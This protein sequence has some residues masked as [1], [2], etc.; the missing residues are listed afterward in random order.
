MDHTIG[1]E[2]W[3]RLLTDLESPP[4]NEPAAVTGE[5]MNNFSAIFKHLQP[6]AAAR[7]TKELEN[8]TIRSI[9]LF[10]EILEHLD[11]HNRPLL[12]SYLSMLL[13]FGYFRIAQV[14]YYI[15]LPQQ[16]GQSSESNSIYY[17]TIDKKLKW[18][19][20]SPLLPK[21]GSIGWKGLMNFG[22]VKEERDLMNICLKLLVQKLHFF[23]ILNNLSQYQDNL[24][25]IRLTGKEV[26]NKLFEL[27]RT[28]AYDED[29]VV[30]LDRSLYNL[31]IPFTDT[32]QQEF[33]NEAIVQDLF[34][35][36][37]FQKPAFEKQAN[38]TYSL[39]THCIL[40]KSS[41][42]ESFF[43]KFINH[44]QCNIIRRKRRHSME[45]SE[46]G[47]A[48]P[49]ALES[50]IADLNRNPET[51]SIDLNKSQE[52]DLDDTKEIETTFVSKT[53]VSLSGLMS[54]VMK[55]ELKAKTFQYSY[56]SNWSSILRRI[57]ED[58]P[59]LTF[60][61]TRKIFTTCTILL[62][63]ISRIENANADKD[64]EDIVMNLSWISAKSMI[65]LGQSRYERF[66]A[67]CDPSYMSVFSKSLAEM[68]M[69]SLFETPLM[70]IYIIYFRKYFA[71][72]D[73]RGCR[74]DPTKM[75]EFVSTICDKKVTRHAS[76]LLQYTCIH[77]LSTLFDGKINPHGK[78]INN[79]AIWT[80][81]CCNKLIK[82]IKKRLI[83]KYDSDDIPTE[84]GDET[85]NI[86]INLDSESENTMALDS[87]ICILKI[88][89]MKRDQT[90]LDT[91]G[92]LVRRLFGSIQNRLLRLDDLLKSGSR[93]DDFAA[94]D[95]H[96][97]KLLQL[98]I[99]NKDLIKVYLDD[100]IVE[101]IAVSWSASLTPIEKSNGSSDVAIKKST[102]AHL[103]T[104]LDALEDKARDNP[105][106]YQTIINQQYNSAVD[107][108]IGSTSDTRKEKQCCHRIL[109]QVRTLSAATAII[110]GG[111]SIT[112]SKVLA[113]NIIKTLE[114][115]DPLDH[116]MVL[117]SILMLKSLLLRYKRD[118]KDQ[119][120]PAIIKLLPNI[121]CGLFRI[122][123]SVELGPSIHAFTNAGDHKS[124]RSIQCCTYSNCVQIYTDLFHLMS[125]KVT[126]T[127]VTDAF[128]LAISSN[129][130][131]YAKHS[132]RLHRYFTSLA[133]SIAELL[134]AICI[135]RK[136]DD[137]L[138]K[139]MPI[140]LSVL[141][142]LMRCIMLAS[143]RQILDGLSSKGDNGQITNEFVCDT[144][145]LAIYEEQL[146]I[147]AL[148][149]GRILNNLS[150]LRVKLVEFAPHL[151]STFVKD[152]QRASCPD[153]IK[154]HLN[155][156][157]FRICNLIDAHQRERREALVEGAGQRKTVSGHASGSLFEMIHAR[158][159]QAS[160]EIFR[161]MHENYSHFHRYLGKC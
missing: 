41:T 77:E 56:L 119:S 1:I 89:V 158:L 120:N 19:D 30:G 75:T 132:G 87:L 81:K 133:F 33:I 61:S 52:G 139:H 157:I 10:E 53:Q 92:D 29:M 127:I 108:V 27:I 24:P 17:P 6:Q 26:A 68:K 135:G 140:F 110:F 34:K 12:C 58:N 95:P 57:L 64:L 78:S 161:D 94:L 153:F 147:L 21:G 129:L 46:E 121:S 69:L 14:I 90:M 114:S 48:K 137:S 28:I 98:Y 79:F 80:T 97:P 144:G 118:T 122:C 9:K 146:E 142:H 16:N 107:I 5:M 67:K 39:I 86:T 115:C 109:K 7:H 96:I 15:P 145:T 18:H 149:I 123:K 112:T 50:I 36:F 101:T 152:L 76:H 116:N 134:K 106:V 25:V 63:T 102:Y 113:T 51:K 130:I 60:V 59:T 128:H 43:H 65:L 72:I 31:L 62:V 84:N 73:Q 99:D 71:T 111:C 154:I 160:R 22:I 13:S 54:D 49:V 66:F 156:G 11:C 40:P 42:Q 8:C 103:K 2:S 131:Q 35:P 125:P 100:D 55:L 141:T 148:D 85:M 74:L 20:M 3:K 93:E 138:K 45:C 117:Y 151:I 105:N 136:D 37:L 143:D 155:E 70:Q 88:A 23:A 44:L 104:K 159:D 150:S 124:N 91:I 83:L 32:K 38:Q 126:S 82:F 47:D 4:D